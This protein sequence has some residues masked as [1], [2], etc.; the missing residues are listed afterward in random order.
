MRMNKDK[1]TDNEVQNFFISY[2]TEGPF[3]ETKTHLF[4][5]TCDLTQQH[6]TEIIKEIYKTR[7]KTSSKK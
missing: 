4:T 3:D 6:K 7:L 2:I 5:H 1:I